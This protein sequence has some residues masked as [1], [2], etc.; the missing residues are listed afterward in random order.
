MNVTVNPQNARLADHKACSRLSPSF[1][2]THV[3][4]IFSSYRQLLAAPCRP[5][6]TNFL[7]RV[8]RRFRD[9]SEEW[10]EQVEDHEAGR[11]DKYGRKT[12]AWYEHDYERQRRIKKRE[13]E[14]KEKEERAKRKKEAEAG[15][16]QLAVSPMMTGLNPFIDTADAPS[17]QPEGAAAAPPITGEPMQPT[18]STHGAGPSGG[19]MSTNM[20]PM[21]SQIS[22]LSSQD[23][24]QPLAA[25]Q[26]AK[27]RAR[28][29]AEQSNPPLTKDSE[30]EEEV[31]D[32]TDSDD[33]DE[34][35]KAAR[36]ANEPRTGSAEGA[37]SGLRGGYGGDGRV[38]DGNDDVEEYNE[39]EDF[40]DEYTDSDKKSPGKPQGRQ[41]HPHRPNKEEEEKWKKMMYQRKN[42]SS[43]E[44]RQRPPH[45]AC[46]NDLDEEEGMAYQPWG[47]QPERCRH[48]Y[49]RHK[50]GP[51]EEEVMAYQPWEK[52]AEC[53]RRP[54]DRPGPKGFTKAR[55][56]EARSPMPRSE[57]VAR[58]S[59][60]DAARDHPRVR[61]AFEF[62]PQRAKT[63]NSRLGRDSPPRLDRLNMDTRVPW[64]QRFV[65]VD[66]ATDAPTFATRP[67]G[68]MPEGS[69][70]PLGGGLRGRPGEPGTRMPRWDG[71]IP[72][73]ASMH[74]W[75][76]T[77]YHW[78]EEEEE[79]EDDDD[80][81]SGSGSDSEFERS[82]RRSSGKRRSKAAAAKS[83]SDNKKS[84][85]D[86]RPTRKD[87]ST[88]KGYPREEPRPAYDMV[89]AAPLNHYAIL[90]LK[91]DA[92]LE[93]IKTASRKMRIRF[94]PDKL[95]KD[96]M[97]E[98]EKATINAK[99]ARIGQAADLL[100]DADQVRCAQAALSAYTDREAEAKL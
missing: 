92:T 87:Q 36:I 95:W 99:S 62:R 42:S 28:A 4:Q 49:R 94:H 48:P 78:L 63:A 33:E 19:W 70:P 2:S 39:H 55:H 93:E 37:A 41:H 84:C 51:E 16:T 45:Q 60:G 67:N 20:S 17:R 32:L 96:G 98:A 1:P 88:G 15:G 80:E 34:V 90:G 58:P 54:Y 23:R 18:G 27:A 73:R 11:R 74:S 24:L 31:S 71:G 40:D 47:K 85:P 86:P 14:M 56:G 100:E 66:R 65:V 10:I 9:A 22:A 76:W 6:L 8:A 7:T 35:A 12:Q 46:V 75:T 3:F 44:T 77:S 29:Q 81:T 30:D 83:S 64:K 91:E 38:K 53:S 97:T 61:V 89:V 57:K 69:I 50:N 43:T 21:P 72:G 52:Q 25:Q 59:Q 13:M 26:R 5:M 82:R 68:R 79:T